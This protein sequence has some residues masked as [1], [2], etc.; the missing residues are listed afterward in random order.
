[1]DKALEA[2]KASAKGNQGLQRKIAT[3]EKN[4]AFLLYQAECMKLRLSDEERV[5]RDKLVQIS[6]AR[7]D[8]EIEDNARQIVREGTEFA[9]RQIKIANDLQ[10]RP[11]Q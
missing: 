10:E 5:E 2:L 11:P 3:M 4:E 9:D 1:M 7:H 8:A 6:R